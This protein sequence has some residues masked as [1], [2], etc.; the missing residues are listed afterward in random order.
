[1]LK[2]SFTLNGLSIK[3]RLVMPPMASNKCDEAGFVTDA[4]CEYYDEKSRGGHIGLIVM[5]HSFIS[6]QG[7]ASKGQL[8][9]ASDEAIPGLQRLTDIIHKNGTLVFAQINHAGMAARSEVTDCEAVGPSAVWP[10]E[11][12]AGALPRALTYPEIEQ[13]KADFVAAAVR[14]KAAG[15]DG[16]QIHSAHGYLLNQFYSPLSNQR[17]GAFGGDLAGRIKLH[18]AIITAIRAAVGEEYP[19]SL[20]LGA[21]DYKEGGSTIADAVIACRA[22]EAAGVDLL[23]ISGGFCGYNRADDKT[24]GYFRDATTAIKA[25]VQTPVILTG[26]ITKAEDAD[27]LLQQGAADLIGVGRAILADSLWAKNAMA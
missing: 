19:I 1:M 27:A 22:F 25:A 15:F 9:M 10:F 2:D 20:R 26:G 17:T 16:V 6:R 21:C 5:E 24:P 14:A 4:L 7:K 3:N 18:L 8:S 11:R 13:I 23:D 12:E